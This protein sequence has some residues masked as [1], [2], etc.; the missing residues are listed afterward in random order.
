M[1]LES[2][3]ICLKLVR[4]SNKV[5]PQYADVH[6]TGTLTESFILNHYTFSYCK[7]KHKPKP[8][9]KSKSK[10]NP[11]SKLKP[12]PKHKPQATLKRNPMIP[13]KIPKHRT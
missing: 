6:I 8:K 2:I 10:P 3:I 13:N 11:K 7:L 9:P 12:K 5:M 4:R 1:F